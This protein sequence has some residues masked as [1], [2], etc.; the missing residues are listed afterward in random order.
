MVS[1]IVTVRSE[2][3]SPAFFQQGSKYTRATHVDGSL[4]DPK[5]AVQPGETI[6]LYGN[7]FGS[8]DPSVIEGTVVTSPAAIIHPVDI[9]IGGRPA[10]IS[11]QAL[12]DTGLYVFLVKVPAQLA[13]GDAAVVAQSDGVQFPDGVFLPVEAPPTGPADILAQIDNF[14]FTPNPVNVL[15]GGKLTGSNN[16][17]EE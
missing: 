2:V 5:K 6:F 7:G 1:S 13:T 3:V 15:T 14:R 10:E 8:T 16:D 4:V 17:T 9:R 12:V 11:Y